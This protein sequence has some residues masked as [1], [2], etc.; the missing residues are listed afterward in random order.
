[1]SE[2]S[3]SRIWLAEL[4]RLGTT[5]RVYDG[6]ALETETREFKTIDVEHTKKVECDA[7]LARRRNCFHRLHPDEVAEL[8]GL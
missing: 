2:I 1:M 7:Y 4:E 8:N 3:K 5:I 6:S